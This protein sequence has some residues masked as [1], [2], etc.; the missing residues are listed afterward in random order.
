MR[1][2]GHT[3]VLGQFDRIGPYKRWEIAFIQRNKKLFK[4]ESIMLN[5]RL[6]SRKALGEFSIPFGDFQCLLASSHYENCT[7][8]ERKYPYLFKLMVALRTRFELWPREKLLTVPCEN[9]TTF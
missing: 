5:G 1:T 2:F 9:R 8:L 4:E 6:K 7:P 3:L